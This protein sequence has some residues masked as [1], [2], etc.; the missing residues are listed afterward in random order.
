MDAFADRIGDRTWQTVMTEEGLQAVRKLLR[1]TA[2]KNTAVACHW[3]RS[4][5]RSDLVWIVGNR[6]QFDAQGRV[7][8]NRTQKSYALDDY[9]GDENHLIG[10][11]LAAGIAGLFHDFGK[12]NVMF[13]RKLQPNEQGK[14]SEPFRHEWVS[15][16]CFEAFVQGKTDAQWLQELATIQTDQSAVFLPDEH[17]LKN[18]NLKQLPNFAQCVA[19][20]IVSHHRL[21]MY[22]HNGQ[23]APSLDADW[24]QEFDAKWNSP[25]VNLPDWTEQD[26]QDNWTF[27]TGLP[28]QSHTWCFKARSLAKRSLKNLSVVAQYQW[29]TWH[30][31]N[32]VARLCLMLSD[33]RYSAAGVTPQWQDQSYLA[34]ANTD[35][36]KQ[37]KQKLDEHNVAVGHYAYLLAKQLPRLMAE[38]PSLGMNQALTKGV[39]ALIEAYQWQEQAYRHTFNIHAEAETQGFFGINMASTGKGKTL[40]NARIM[41][42]LGGEQGGGRFCIATGLRTLTTQTG[43]ALASR[44][45]LEDDEIATVIG[46][47]AIQKLQANQTNQVSSA[48]EKSFWQ[49]Q[50]TSLWAQR[51]SESLE[52]DDDN[53]MLI[54]YEHDEF[55]GLLNKCLGHNRK[56]LKF[57]HAPILVCTVDYLIPATEGVKGGKQ[58]VPMLRL[59]GSDLILDEPDEFGLEDL[60]A[61]TRLV[62]WAGLLGS[63]VLLSSATI[64]PAMA[65]ALFEA[66]QHGRLCYMREAKKQEQPQAIVCA[67]FDEFT[68]TSQTCLGAEA[69][70]QAHIKFVN[71]RLSALDQQKHISRYAKI[72]P[73]PMPIQDKNSL[74]IEIAK[75]LQAACLRL[76]QVHHEQ[77]QQYRYS[78]GLLRFAN[79]QPLIAVAQALMS[80]PIAEGFE[81]HF[82]VYHSQFTLAQRS[83]IEE[84]LDRILKR[85]QKNALWSHAEVRDTI[86]K[87]PD[88]QHLFIVLA[89]SVAEV[90]R[91]HDYDWAIVEPSSA[92]SL[93]QLAGRL[94]RHRQMKVT[95]PNLLIWEHNYRALSRAVEVTQAVFTQP[96]FERSHTRYLRDKNVQQC[97]TEK[98]Y[99]F[100]DSKVSIS[101]EWDLL[102]L[103]EKMPKDFGNLIHLEHA[104]YYQVL[105]GFGKDSPH[106]KDNTALRTTGYAKLWWQKQPFWCGELQRRQGFR[107]SAPE[108]V[109]LRLINEQGKPAWYYR[110]EHDYD[111]IKL[112]EKGRIQTVALQP[113]T[114]NTWWF[115]QTEEGRYQEIADVLQTNMKYVQYVFGEIRIA[116][117]SYGVGTQ[118]YQYHPQLGIFKQA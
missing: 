42:A 67:W 77:Q 94:Q 112:L 11:A 18:Q 117:Y 8:V 36:D 78:V 59:M 49:Q 29:Q 20:L 53:E 91:D 45:G 16:K 102:K 23:V 71:K 58:I 28:S 75:H 46:S 98:Q 68:A 107:R 27:A 30:L 65:Q 54:Q 57:L 69:F 113:I 104:A 56:W 9:Q 3:L 26:K 73:M 76:H 4:R 93:I 24:L 14:K 12:A 25:R 62:H 115:E 111:K 61:L 32:H 43:S 31:S 47:S 51:G 97:M 89:T 48:Q 41:Y 108:L 22:I 79:I 2:S 63:K 19:W 40:A 106:Q 84:K 72:L 64:P 38:L 1:K 92:R 103:N 90:G 99:K 37:L 101:T 83:A 55:D 15:L 96:G 70:Q 87:S 86:M 85:H 33:H 39:G 118:I 13:Q 80:L 110:D 6:Q 5:S 116:D 52:S 10:V 105:L 50:E 114:G 17:Y 66:Y 100:P 44:L 109:W 21:P 81:L 82:C 74:N 88:K 95:T 7:A 35:A 34:Y 60:P